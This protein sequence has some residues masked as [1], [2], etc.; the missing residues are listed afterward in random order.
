M[1]KHS[2]LLQNQ[3]IHE[4]MSPLDGK[5]HVFPPI[6]S[7]KGTKTI[8]P[9]CDVKKHTHHDYVMRI[10]LLGDQG[11]GKS[12]F[13]KALKVHPDVKKLECKCRLAQT[14]DHLELEIATALG[15]TALVRL[16]DTGG[17]ERF[18]S[19]TS[20]Y[21]RGAHGALL[22]FDLKQQRS[23]SNV[24]T[25]LSDL[26]SFSAPSSCTRVLLGSN[27]TAQD[28]EVTSQVAKRYAENRSLSYMEFDASQFYNVIESL[29][30][31]VER[32]ANEVSIT[33]ACPHII[34][35]SSRS[36]CSSQCGEI[37]RFTC[38]C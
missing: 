31:M 20:S 17:Q 16:C 24:E 8:T 30:M 11:V 29:Q 23:L 13:I 3:I 19:L 10:I 37:R 35:P 18:R 32:I 36:S 1:K 25:W 15:K 33:P 28:R 12:S 26:E 38:L 9:R 4:N 14:T 34:K 21:Y 2:T 5:S 27:C 7:P 6:T 22:V